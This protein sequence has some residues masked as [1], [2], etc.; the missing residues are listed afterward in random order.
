VPELLHRVTIEAPIEAVWAELTRMDGKQRA[1]M[2]TVLETTL[3]PGAPLYYKSPDGKRVFIVGRV[4]EVEPPRLLQHTQRLTMRD[5]PFTVVT[6]ELEQVGDQTQVTLRHTGWPED[7]KKLH[8]VDGTWASIMPELKRLLETG[9]ISR[10]MRLRYRL[11]S[12]FT[13]AL[14]AKTKTENVPEPPMVSVR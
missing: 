13:W 11:Y 12:A 14:P 4:I 3:E 6:W 10:G 7:T 1:M 5:D 9:Q 8:Q 2:D